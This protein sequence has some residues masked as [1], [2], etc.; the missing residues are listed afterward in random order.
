MSNPTG[1]GGFQ[2]HPELIN[3][4]GAPKRGQSWGESTKRLTDMTRDELVEYVGGKKTRIGRLLASA[5][6]N[7]PMKDAMVIAATV[8]F[9]IDPN[10][11]MFKALSDR[12]DGKP[13][14]PISGA[15][16]GPLE[17]TV[18]YVQS[19]SNPTDSAS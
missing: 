12:E 16:G 14:Q 17:I 19:K 6:S 7:I 2:D 10:P 8:A 13:N 11:N 9:L 1:K 18:E 15:D 5:T 4:E 3:K